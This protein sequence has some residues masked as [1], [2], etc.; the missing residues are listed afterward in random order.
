M[1]LQSASTATSLPP[2]LIMFQFGPHFLPQ[3]FIFC[4]S[5]LIMRSKIRYI[6]GR[7]NDVNIIRWPSPPLWLSLAA[8]KEDSKTMLGSSPDISQGSFPLEPSFSSPEA[9]DLTRTDP[10]RLNS[11]PGK[12]SLATK[13]PQ[14]CRWFL[15]NIYYCCFFCPCIIWIHVQR[16]RNI[17]I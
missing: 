12:W 10:N 15:P 1:L 7:R 14:F 9:P 11:G 6:S 8:R 4:S 5:S 16:S 17:Y 13:S 3:A 2:P